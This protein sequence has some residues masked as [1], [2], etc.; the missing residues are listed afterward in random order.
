[1]VQHQPNSNIEGTATTRYHIRRE[2]ASIWGSRN[3]KTSSRFE[4]EALEPISPKRPVVLVDE[5][6]TNLS[7]SPSFWPPQAFHPTG[8]RLRATMT[9]CPSS[10]IANS[11][12]VPNA[13]ESENNIA[14]HCQLHVDTREKLQQ[15]ESR[16]IQRLYQL[17][18]LVAQEERKQNQQNLNEWQSRALHFQP[19]PE[20]AAHLKQHKDDPQLRYRRTKVSAIVQTPGYSP[21][22]QRIQESRELRKKRFALRWH[23]F[24]RLLDAMRRTPCRRPV[25][26]DMEKLYALARELGAQ[27]ALGTCTLSRNQFTQL[28]TREFPLCDLKHVNRLFSSYDYELRDSVDAR[29]ILGTIRAMRVQQ[30]EPVELICASLRDFDSTGEVNS[31]NTDDSKA[32]VINGISLAKALTLC[33]SSD[34]EEQDMENRATSIWTKTLLWQRQILSRRLNRGRGYNVWKTAINSS[35]DYERTSDEISSKREDAELNEVGGNVDDE[36]DTI[37]E[38]PQLMQFVEESRVPVRRI[39]AA[40]KRENSTL[41]LFTQQLLQRRHE[42]L[43]T[44][45]ASS[46]RTST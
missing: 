33:C 5:F 2:A 43:V 23:S 21:E 39:R 14:E 7:G 28:V 1:M 34:E 9:R 41:S 15:N 6:V 26:Q 4:I 42:C 24:A 12:Q 35:A 46:P 29:I 19:S 38:V 44:A 30:G 37:E 27:N 31:K 25:L 36:E 8:S 20:L 10:P 11:V 16:K 40:L 13:R 22:K 45:S 17:E 18:K 32:V 3:R